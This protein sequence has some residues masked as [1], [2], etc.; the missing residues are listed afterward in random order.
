[1]HILTKILN[2]REDCFVLSHSLPYLIPGDANH[3]E[4][5][6]KLSAP[7]TETFKRYA[8]KRQP[9]TAALVKGARAQGNQRVVTTGPEDCRRRDERVKAAWADTEAIRQKY[10]ALLSGPFQHPLR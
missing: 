4:N 9:R 5:V 10:D 1:M 6:A 3:E 8:D 7:L 2:N